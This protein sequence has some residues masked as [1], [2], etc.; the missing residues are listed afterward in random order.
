[1]PIRNFIDRNAEKLWKGISIA[2]KYQ[3]IDKQIARRLN[4]LNAAVSIDDLRDL[5]S[6][7]FE[8]LRG[9]PAG[10]YS[11]R[12]NEKTRIVFKWDENGP[13]DVEIALDYH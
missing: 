3:A 1:M 5:P 10:R 8:A 13:F 2:K 12:V 4:L 7:R 9:K 6:N 11:I